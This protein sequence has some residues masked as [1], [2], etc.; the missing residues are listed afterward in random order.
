M[1]PFF[2]VEH[3]TT[4]L[5]KMKTEITVVDDVNFTV[6]NGETICIVGESGCGKSMTALSILRLLGGKAVSKGRVLY[7]NLDLL[8][9]SSRKMEAMRGK[10]MNIVFQNS[11][12]ALNPVFTIGYQMRKTIALHLKLS[13]KDAVNYSIRLLREVGISRP[14][15][16][17]SEYPH[18]LSGGMRQRVAIALALSCKP[19]L[20]I[21][22]EPTTALDATIQAQ[23]LR[24]IKEIQKE[25]D[26]SLILITHD[27]GVVSE[28]ADKIIVMYA[29]QIVE[30]AN[31]YD[32]FRRASHPYT[33]ALLNSVKILNTN[34]KNV[35]R[36]MRIHG[37]IPSVYQDVSGCRFHNRCPF[38]MK[39]CKSEQPNL[40]KVG[41]DHWARCWL[42]KA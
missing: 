4:T 41:E 38:A 18:T 5:K 12:S 20:L 28:M 17:I 13:K 6:K 15:A 23:I 29:G 2:Q 42:H 40:L 34:I 14:E 8:K 11:L 3:L 33:I 27:F 36:A 25:T 26:L 19:K 39:I 7:N 16:I 24:L 32:L 22:D 37:N 31:V 9:L 30:E 35:Q 10:A 21:A 1:P